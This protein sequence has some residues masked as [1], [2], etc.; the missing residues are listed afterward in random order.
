[1]C[2]SSLLRIPKLYSQLNNHQQENV[3]SHQNHTPHPREKEKPQQ[4]GRRGKIAFRIKPFCTPDQT[5][6]EPDLP[7]SVQV[8]PV[9]VWV[10][11]GL[12]QGQGLWMQ[13]TWV[14]HKPSWRRSPLIPPWRHQTDHPQ[15]AEQLYQINSYTAEKVLRPTTDF[16]IW[17]SGKGTE[18]PQGIWLWKP[19]AFDYG[20]YTGLGKQTLGRHK[21]NFVC[22]GPRR[23]SSDPIRNWPRLACECPGVSRRNTGQQWPTTGSGAL[24]DAVSAWDLLKDVTIVFITSTIVWSQVKQQG[25]NTVLPVN[26]KLD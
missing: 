12:P 21:H 9:E 2:S 20:I 4:D 8:S 22:T 10:S 11:S 3:G 17:G 24:S 13:Q 5:E 18:K 6:T 15:T 16:P 19:V 1:M 25:G 7:L 23:R 14:W 26:R